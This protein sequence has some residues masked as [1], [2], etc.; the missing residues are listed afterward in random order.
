MSVLHTCCRTVAL[1]AVL[2][3]AGGCIRSEPAAF[4]PYLEGRDRSDAERYSLARMAELAQHLDAAFGTPDEPKLPPGTDLDLARLQSAAGP[5]S[6]NQRGEHRGLYREHCSSCHGITGEG[7]GPT[8]YFLTPYP[9]DFARGVFKFTSTQVGDRPTRA[10]LRRTIELGIPGT[11]M[12]SFGLLPSADLDALVEYVRYLSL[13]GEY[14][15]LAASQ[16]FDLDESLPS[17]GTVAELLEP[18]AD[19]WRQAE[20][21]ARQLAIGADRPKDR[22]ASI[23]AGRALFL[24]ANFACAKCHGQD[25]NGTGATGTGTESHFDI[26]N[27]PKQGLTT[28]AVLARFN[29]PLAAIQPRNLRQGVMHGGSRPEDIYRRIAVGVKGTPMPGYAPP[30]GDPGAASDKF[31]SPAQIWNLVDYIQSLRVG[32]AELAAR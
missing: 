2:W 31:L 7:A 14:A 24:D 16:L 6:S 12:P 23:A 1:V 8:A 21:P 9:R 26:W 28:A 5:V 19:S 11:A 15:A 4:K 17:D 3:G 20:E 18:L 32:A 10:D 22:A 29:L 13:R 27:S 25:A 30:S